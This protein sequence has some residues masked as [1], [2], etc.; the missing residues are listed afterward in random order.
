MNSNEYLPIINGAIIT[1]FVAIIL[2]L[3]KFVKTKSLIK[4][5]R[6]FH[7]LAFMADIL[8]IALGVIIAKNIY[9]K[10]F[11]K[12]L[13]LYFIILVVLVQLTHDSL[14]GLFVYKFPK[15]KSQIID[16]FKDYAD[17]LSF[18]ILFYDASMM[19]LTVFISSFLVTQSFNTNMTIFLFCLYLLPYLLLSI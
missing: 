2:I 6:Q 7:I 11:D 13:L 1:D 3:S 12:Y 16:I 9:Y 4:W 15:N 19:V 10:I 5:Y 18:R 14:F 17:E 8:S